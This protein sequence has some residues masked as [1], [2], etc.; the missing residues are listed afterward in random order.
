ME[1]TMMKKLFLLGLITL[2]GCASITSE[3][4]QSVRIEVE[5]EAG[6][7][8]SNVACTL[9]NDKGIYTVTPPGNVLVKKSSKDLSVICEHE[10][11]ESA[12]G[13]LVSRAGAGMWGNIVFGGGI[14]AIIDHNKGTAYNYPEWVQ[15][16]IGQY[17][18]FDRS[19][20]NDG[21]PTVGESNTST[22][23]ETP[24]EEETVAL[25]D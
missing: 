8:V 4:T 16:I 17:L 13:V 7:E 2:T 18:T 22:D 11:E 20:H 6:V 15:L 21:K 24:L 14:G 9:E 19:K 23:S 10:V 25:K 5:D 3:G 1:E 12:K